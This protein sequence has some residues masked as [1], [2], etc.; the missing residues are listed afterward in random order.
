MKIA[1]A[2]TI[3]LPQ[4][5]GKFIKLERI[6]KAEEKVVWALAATQATVHKKKSG[7]DSRK[8]FHSQLSGSRGN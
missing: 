1:A 5:K 3:L 2:E 4:V 7:T 6:H 8:A